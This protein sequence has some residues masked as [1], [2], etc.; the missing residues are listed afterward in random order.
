M[1]P[2]K[3]GTEARTH[4]HARTHMFVRMYM[5]GHTANALANVYNNSLTFISCAQQK[6][7]SC[8]QQKIVILLIPYSGATYGSRSELS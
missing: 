4:T 1:V 7:V 5:Y 8:A 6:I 2:R 3:R